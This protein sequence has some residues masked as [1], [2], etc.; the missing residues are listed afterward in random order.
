MKVGVISLGCSKNL[1]NTE[2]MMFLLSEAGFEVTQ[3]IPGVDFALLNTC[4]FIESAKTEAIETIIELGEMKQRGEIGKLIVAGCLPQRY[5][6][7]IMSELPEI[8]AVV[9]TGSFDEIIDVANALI[10][11]DEISGISTFRDIN[12]PVSETKRII[13]TSSSWAYLKVAE[14]CDN[15]CAYCVIP[16]IRGKFRSRPIE[17]IVAEA[18]DLIARGIKELI[19]VAQDV[20][21]YGTDLYEKRML[22]TLLKELCNIE[23]LDWIRL[24]YLYPSEIDDNLIDFISSHDKI[25]K[26]LDIPIQHINTDVLK[27][28]NRRGTGE[29]IRELFERIR[30]RIP[31]I[32]LRTSIIA[33][34]PGETEKSFDELCD[35]L[36]QAKIER[37]GVFEYSPEEGSLAASMDRPDVSI[38]AKRAEL[39]TDLQSRIMEEFDLTRIGSVVTVLVEGKDESGLYFGRSFAESPDVDGY[40]TIEG[41]DLPMNEFIEVRITDTSEGVVRGEPLTRG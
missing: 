33:G 4:G 37:A 25:L 40:I 9:G 38:V 8:D 26:Y 34:L 12:A 19:I 11:K 16:S 41:T 29:E 20:T 21:M 2:Q 39:L 14:G 32:V 30:K 5:K 22:T 17:N 1:I 28:M 6:D 24:H 31:G 35:F 15:N 23:E 7:E 13:S 18:R 36:L 3:E 10:K 27:K